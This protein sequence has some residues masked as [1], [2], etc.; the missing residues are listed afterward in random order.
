MKTLQKAEQRVYRF[1]CDTCRSLFEMTAAEKV[2][3]DWKY[4]DGVAKRED[5]PTAMP[6]NFPWKFDCPV[7]GKTR[8]AASMSGRV[9]DIMDT[10]DEIIR[11]A[12]INM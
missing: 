1:R 10:G 5:G 12:N 8:F 2:E 9:I 4:H 3:N 7:C 11:Y 6:H